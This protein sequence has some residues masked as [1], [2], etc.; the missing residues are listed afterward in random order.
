MV[1][2]ASGQPG[3]FTLAGSW[4]SRCRRRVRPACLRALMLNAHRPEAERAAAPREEEEEEGD[5]FKG[6]KE[7]TPCACN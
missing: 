7:G 6:R 5:I 2:P 1:L 3:P 4:T